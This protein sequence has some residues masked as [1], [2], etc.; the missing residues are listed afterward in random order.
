MV[1][2][3]DIN[4]I[5]MILVQIVYTTMVYFFGLLKDRTVLHTFSSVIRIVRLILSCLIY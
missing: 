4:F 3:C 1:N 5:S 2:N